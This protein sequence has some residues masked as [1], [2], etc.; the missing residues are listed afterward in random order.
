MT[1]GGFLVLFLVVMAVV[2][3]A[4]WRHEQN[5]RKKAQAIASAHGLRY[6]PGP[7]HPPAVPFQQLSI[8]RSRQARHTMWREGDPNEA[9]VFEYRYTT[10]SGKNSQTHTLTCAV[11]RTGLRAPHMTLDRQGFFRGLLQTL[12]LRDIQVESPQFNDTWHVSCADERFAITVLDPP[13]INWLMTLGG[14]GAVEIELLG[15]R[16]LAITRKLEL[17]QLP[18]LLGYTH[19]FIDRI[20]AVVHDLYPGQR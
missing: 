6:L 9:A 12:G 17:E 15:D 2:L 1:A 5:R 8:G 18:S 14:G 16:G 20:P 10:G 3:V 13:M 19:Q 11:F 7:N 4:A